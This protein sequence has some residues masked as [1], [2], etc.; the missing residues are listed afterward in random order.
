MS[1]RRG[2]RL[3]HWV[4]PWGRPQLRS[5]ASVLCCR[6]PPPQPGHP[7]AARG[8]V[9]APAPAR[10]QPAPAAPGQ[11]HATSVQLRPPC[12]GPGPGPTN[13]FPSR[14]GLP[15]W[16]VGDPRTPTLVPWWQPQKVDVVGPWLSPDMWTQA[17]PHPSL[18]HPIIHSLLLFFTV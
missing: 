17:Q 5:C 16:Q 14:L 10:G 6:L 7:G 15:L 12:P 13:R 11:P 3:L 4:A 9:P 8:G 1:P 18:V 2:Q